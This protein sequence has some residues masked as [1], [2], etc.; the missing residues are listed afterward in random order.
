[1]AIDSAGAF[2]RCRF[3][4]PPSTSGQFLLL[5]TYPVVRFSC[6]QL[7]A[8]LL[9]SAF[10]LHDLYLQ[11]LVRPPVT[12]TLQNPAKVKQEIEPLLHFLHVLNH[13]PCFMTIMFG[14]AIS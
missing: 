11:A 3:T 12:V 13:I 10:L 6:C 7:P 2:H 8:G 14:V 5:L 1:M 9:N 4:R